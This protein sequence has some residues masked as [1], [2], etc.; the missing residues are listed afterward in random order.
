MAP[1]ENMVPKVHPLSRDAEADDPLELMADM[2]VGDP[3]VMLDCVLQEFAWM[4]FSAEQ[5]LALFHH[6]GYPVLCEL[7]GFLGEEVVRSRIEE[8]V[9]RWGVLQFREV[10]AEP[11]PDDDDAVELVQLSLKC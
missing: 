1:D 4:G 6:P 11:D 5:L 8:L 10:H 9:S 3:D 2:A 7:R